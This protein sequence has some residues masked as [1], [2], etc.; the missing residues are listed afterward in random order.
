[1]RCR[2]P[3]SVAG[4]AAADAGDPLYGRG[5]HRNRLH[6]RRPDRPVIVAA[7]DTARHEVLV[8]ALASPITDRASARSRQARA[9]GASPTASK[10]LAATERAAGTRRRRVRSGST[11]IFRPRTTRSSSSTPT[12]RTRRRSP[13]A[14]ISPSRRSARRRGVIV[15]RDNAPIARG[16]HDNWIRRKAGAPRGR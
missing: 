14:S 4:P 6:A 10:R 7:I 15:L 9:G 11:A 5:Q 3:L 13:A 16:Y 12:R 8:Q 1:M 2:L